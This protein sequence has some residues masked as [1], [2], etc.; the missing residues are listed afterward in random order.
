MRLLWPL[1]AVLLLSA[2]GTTRIGRINADPTRYQNRGVTVEG[3]VTNSFGALGTGGYQVDDGTGR[4]FVV[5]TGSGVP[6]KGSRVAVSGRVISG[7]TV[8]GKAFGTSIRESRHK[9]KW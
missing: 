9:V 7:A 5:S 8:M 2:C 1:A 6:S 3:T 4:I